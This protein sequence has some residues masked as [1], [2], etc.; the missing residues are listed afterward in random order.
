MQSRVVTKTWWTND[1]VSFPWGCCNCYRMWS[2]RLQSCRDTA[3]NYL[4]PSKAK[5]GD[6]FC[7][8]TLAANF[9]GYFKHGRYILP[10]SAEMYVSS[11]KPYRKI[12]DNDYESFSGL[13]L[14]LV[15]EYLLVDSRHVKR[16]LSCFLTVELHSQS[17]FYVRIAKRLR[18]VQTLKQSW[19]PSRGTVS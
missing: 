19:C 9:A 17:M 4:H 12:A 14:H 11:L 7:A 3:L 1:A 10:G 13:H 16:L 5:S 18:P 6:H 15:L 2:T 8:T